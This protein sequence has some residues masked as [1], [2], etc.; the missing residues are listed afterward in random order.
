[1]NKF[2]VCVH[3]HQIISSLCNILSSILDIH[4]L[5]IASFESSGCGLW[6]LW[7]ICKAN[8]ENFLWCV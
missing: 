4:I 6:F 3:I 1:M 8:A 7:Y 5:E 2:H